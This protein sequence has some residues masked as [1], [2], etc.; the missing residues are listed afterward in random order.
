ME[1]ITVPISGDAQGGLSQA[2]RASGP[3]HMTAKL[4][5]HRSRE[6]GQPASRW[7]SG[8]AR[9][10][11]SP[12]SPRLQR[13]GELQRSVQAFREHSG[14]QSVL[15]AVRSLNHFFHSFELQDWLHRPKNLQ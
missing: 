6:P 9:P 14:R 13:G 7:D 12:D 2:E 4:S 5:A 3:K 1:I 15:Q 10:L 8:D 11:H